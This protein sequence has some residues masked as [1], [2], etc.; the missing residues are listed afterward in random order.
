MAYVWIINF[1]HHHIIKLEM[2]PSPYGV[3]NPL[4]ELQ[5]FF[6]VGLMFFNKKTQQC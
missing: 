5:E 4:A 6:F 2:V 1:P 3:L